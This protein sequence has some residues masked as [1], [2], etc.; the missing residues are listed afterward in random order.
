METVKMSQRQFAKDFIH[1]FFNKKRN[2]AWH[3][4]CT[5]FQNYSHQKMIQNYENGK[6]GE[7]NDMFILDWSE[8]YSMKNGPEIASKQH[9]TS[10]NCQILGIIDL[11]FHKNK[12]SCVSHFFLSSK[13]VKKNT[14]TSLREL[15]ELIREKMN[16]KNVK[17]IHLWSDG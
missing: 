13:N 10:H 14:K 8:D 17:I 16:E 6:N 4:S 9:Y 5:H 2:F 11:G 7:E 1:F 3:Y 15:Q 12:F